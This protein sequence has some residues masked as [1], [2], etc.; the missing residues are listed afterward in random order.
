[1]DLKQKNEIFNIYFLLRS[2]I[3][4]ARVVMSQWRYIEQ[5]LSMRCAA[6]IIGVAHPVKKF[7][8]EISEAMA[9]IR[10][11]K[12]TLLKD[13]MSY[14]VVDLCSGNALVPLISAF[15]LPSKWNWAVDIAP[16]KRQ[17]E[18]VKRFSY[19]N[20]NIHEKFIKEYINN[21]DGPVIL[22]ASHACKNLAIQ[23]TELYN[24]TKAEML[25]LMPCCIGKITQRISNK[26]ESRIG[27]DNLWALHL[28]NLVNGR[29]I[30]D[31]D[32]ISPKN[33]IIIANKR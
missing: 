25:V 21:L 33:R 1:M 4:K 7:A 16:R 22:T 32:V 6:D 12:A 28:S 20:T 13:P 23:T 11:I 30:Q 15:S 3:Q 5:F 27:R 14:N 24:N 31:D 2:S 8:K 17:W 26:M 9:I 18:K 29:L 10:R 19:I